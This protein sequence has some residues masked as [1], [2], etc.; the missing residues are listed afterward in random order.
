MMLMWLRSEI[1][2]IRVARV[3]GD[4]QSSSFRSNARKLRLHVAGSG[5]YGNFKRTA[6]PDLEPRPASGF[7]FAVGG[8][9]LTRLE[10]LKLVS[11]IVDIRG[12]DPQSRHFR[13]LRRR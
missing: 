5:A 2:K 13:K 6:H 8:F 7:N 1:R 9:D 10:C 4:R 12:E 11:A 3:P